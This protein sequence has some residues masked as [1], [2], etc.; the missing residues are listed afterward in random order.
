MTSRSG[1]TTDDNVAL[2]AKTRRGRNPPHQKI[3][4]K[5][6]Y[7]GNFKGKVFDMSKIKCFHCNKTRHFAKDCRSKKRGFQKG[8]HHASTAK[9]GGSGKKASESPER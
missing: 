2:A 5:S 7:K 3:F 4:Q 8:K 1:T 6:K 9:E